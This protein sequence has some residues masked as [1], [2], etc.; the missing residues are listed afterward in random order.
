[1]MLSGS[2]FRVTRQ[3]D[4][5]KAVLRVRIMVYFHLELGLAPLEIRMRAPVGPYL[6]RLVVQLPQVSEGG[7]Y[8]G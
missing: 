8:E 7:G 1:M 4:P 2:R 6:R 5:K 3:M